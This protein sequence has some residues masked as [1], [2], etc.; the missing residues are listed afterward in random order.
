MTILSMRIAC[1]IAKPANTH[2]LKICNAYCFS[3]AEIVVRTRRNVTFYVHCLS[4]KYKMQ[5]K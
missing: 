2:T 4:Y 3:T 1:W 5:F